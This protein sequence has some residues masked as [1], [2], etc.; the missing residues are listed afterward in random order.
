MSALC[1]MRVFIVARK[2]PQTAKLS[3]SDNGCREW[4]VRTSHTEAKTGIAIFSIW[5]IAPL[6]RWPPANAFRVGPDLVPM[7]WKSWLLEA[8]LATGK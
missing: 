7:N 8:S 4:L 6:C 3:P 2:A 1:S 5:F